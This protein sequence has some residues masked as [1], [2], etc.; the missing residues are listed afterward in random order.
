MAFWARRRLAP[1]FH[2]LRLLVVAGLFHCG[3]TCPAAWCCFCIFYQPPPRNRWFLIAVFHQHT[4]EQ[5]DS[6]FPAQVCAITMTAIPP[7]FPKFLIGKLVLV[8]RLT[9][10]RIQYGRGMQWS[11]ACAGTRARCIGA[12][13]VVSCRFHA[14]SFERPIRIW[15]S[16]HAPRVC[17]FS[18]RAHSF[19]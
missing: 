6:L 11:P 10:R 5:S 14:F 7:F 13:R 16:R 4:L 1:P 17:A 8:Y 15:T 19:L 18:G 3:C 12:L 9:P 2:G